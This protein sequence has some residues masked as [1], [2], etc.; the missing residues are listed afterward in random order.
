MPCDIGNRILGYWVCWKAIWKILHILSC[1]CTLRYFNIRNGLHA[2]FEFGFLAFYDELSC[3]KLRH[4]IVLCWFLFWTTRGMSPWYLHCK[5]SVKPPSCLLGMKH[6]A[7]GRVQVWITAIN[8]NRAQC[9]W[10]KEYSAKLPCTI[11]VKKRPNYQL[12]SQ[13]DEMCG[14]KE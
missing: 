4:V 14:Q 3:D 2:L 13:L 6:S 9:C 10:K 12:S 8:E 5:G 11:K 7:S 1:L